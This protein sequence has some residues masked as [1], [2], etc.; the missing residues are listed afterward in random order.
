MKTVLSN[1]DGF[2][3]LVEVVEINRP[4]KYT[5]LSFS[6]EWDDARRDGSEQQSFQVILSPE[7][8]LFLK[9]LL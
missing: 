7:Q 1:N 4:A 9:E 5:K 6:T 2:K 8:R 3:Y